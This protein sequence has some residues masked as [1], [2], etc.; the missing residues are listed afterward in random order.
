LTAVIASMS[1]SRVLILPFSID[2]ALV[3]LTAY[4][5]RRIAKAD[6]T[7]SRL[8]G[9][10]WLGAVLI[11]VI[12]NANILTLVVPDSDLLEKSIL[13]V[14]P[15]SVVGTALLLFSTLNA[16]PLTLTRAGRRLDHRRDWRR[17]HSTFPLLI[18]TLVASMVRYSPPFL[19]LI[20]AAGP[21]GGCE[22]LIGHDYFAQMTQGHPATP[23]R[24]WN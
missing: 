15:A 23:Y 14:T 6:G 9:W 3:Y 24:T 18:G 20:S 11:A 17:V 2:V 13:F 4:F 21:G 12:D 5:K 19:H 16:D 10:W 22:Q 1:D 8:W 7:G